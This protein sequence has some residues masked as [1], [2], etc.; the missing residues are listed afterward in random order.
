M[1]ELLKLTFNIGGLVRCLTCLSTAQSV[2]VPPDVFRAL[3]QQFLRRNIQCVYGNG[4]WTP[5]KPAPLKV[6]PRK[7]VKKGSFPFQSVTYV[8][9]VPFAANGTALKISQQQQRNA[10]FQ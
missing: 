3:S 2:F 5:A 1:L 7:D 10:L 6:V 4:T 8:N 9:A